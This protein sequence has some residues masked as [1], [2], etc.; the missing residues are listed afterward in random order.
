MDPSSKIF[1]AGHRGLAGAAL[2][3]SLRSAGFTNLPTRTHAEL[4]LE[5]PAQVEA[6]FAAERP[7]YVFL[8]AARV[9]GIH[10]NSTYPLDFLLR[11]LKIQNNVLESSWRHGVQGLLFLGSSCIYPRLAPQPLKEVHLLRGLLEPT[12]EP[13]AIAKI[14]GIELCAAFNRQH[15]TRFLSV[16]PTNLYGPGDNYD[17]ETS[18]VL[19]AFIRKFH[20][21]TLASR[22]DWDAVRR[23][24]AT[25]GLLPG[26]FKTHLEAIASSANTGALLPPLILWGSGTPRREFLH[27]DDLAD[28]CLFL[29]QRL[30]SLFSR[31]TAASPAE[32]ASPVTRHLFNIGC[33]E[34][35]PLSQLAAL[36]ARI[37]GYTGPIAWDTSRPDGTPQKLLDTGRLDAMG[38]KPRISLEEGILRT[39]T[40]YKDR[41]LT[42]A[43]KR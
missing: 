1:V 40:D 18:H 39:Y 25:Y 4:D 16:M 22:S 35:L 29:M 14:A 3:R 19:P 20:L 9:G 24:E 6:F 28:A 42:S 13:Y 27:S 32:D 10:A 34:D 43:D 17:L 26:D 31:A 37:T 36:V 11:N 38:W 33:G 15:G 12:N 2:I 8:A 5:N 41:T 7:T 21:A 23:D 30:D